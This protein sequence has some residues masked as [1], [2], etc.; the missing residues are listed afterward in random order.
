MSS[1]KK[2]GKQTN[3]ATLSPHGHWLG[4]LGP[5]GGHRGQAHKGTGRVNRARKPGAPT[6]SPRRSE[7]RAW[8]RGGP[9]FFWKRG[10]H[11]PGGIKD[12][13]SQSQPSPRVAISTFFHNPK[14]S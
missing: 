1:Q 7:E 3:A 6:T 14:V 13:P 5:G 4:A 9:C 2:N 11:H 12:L 8:N 10:S